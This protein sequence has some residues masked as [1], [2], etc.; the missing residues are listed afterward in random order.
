[1]RACA[2]RARARAVGPVAGLTW[3]YCVTSPPKGNLPC[4]LHAG[5]AT[6]AVGRGAEEELL[7][8]RREVGRDQR[9]RIDRQARRRRGHEGR[10][11]TARALAGLVGQQPRGQVLERVGEVIRVGAVGGQPA[12]ID[13]EVLGIRRVARAQVVHARVALLRRRLRGRHRVGEER[14]ELALVLPEAQERRVEL[15]QG[16]VE[17]GQQ[18]MQLVEEV[19]GRRQA[20][21][22][23]VEQRVEV[24]EQGLELGGE[25]REVLQRGRQLARGG[26]QLGHERVGVLGELRSGA[27]G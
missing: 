13:G 21:H 24:G 27:R 10:V 26:A 22:G 6:C 11:R 4:C 9:G 5:A 25:L 1:M 7:H 8:V 18:R 16:R 20:L 12:R 15:A 2:E 14:A 19:L 17:V 3:G 23:G